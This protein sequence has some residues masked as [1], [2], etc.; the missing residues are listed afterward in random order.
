MQ[1]CIIENLV[2]GLENEKYKIETVTKYQILMLP[3]WSAC[4]TT[5]VVRSNK[6]LEF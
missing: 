2:N 1:N 3:K 4:I 6:P 5:T